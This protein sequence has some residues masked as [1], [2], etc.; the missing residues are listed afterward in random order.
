M[1]IKLREVLNHIGDAKV[2]SLGRVPYIQPARPINEAGP[3]VCR[4]R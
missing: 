3:K 2:S 4:A 1:C